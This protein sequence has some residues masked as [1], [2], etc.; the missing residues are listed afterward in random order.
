MS[1]EQLMLT[2]DLLSLIPIL[3]LAWLA[4][5]LRQ[6]AWRLFLSYCDIFPTIPGWRS[7][8]SNIWSRG[9]LAG[10]AKYSPELRLLSGEFLI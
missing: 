8:S 2:E 7:F 1:P 6:G 9:R 4:S 10:L 3:R 5:E